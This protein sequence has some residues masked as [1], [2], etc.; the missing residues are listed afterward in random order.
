MSNVR[1]HKQTMSAQIDHIV[2]VAPSL[3]AGSQFVVQSLGVAPGPGRKHPHMGSHNLLLSLG[4]SVY[5]EVAAA[6]PEAA[7]IS[8]RRWFGLDDVTHTS[9]SRLAAWVASTNQI[10]SAASPEYGHAETMRREGRAWQMT[11]TLDGSP[12]LSGAAPVLIQRSGS[13]H[14]AAALA[15]SGLRL[16][17]F[18]IETPDAER[19]RAFLARIDL[20][21]VEVCVVHGAV[22]K[23]IAEIETPLG[24]RTLGD[25]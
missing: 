9:P 15:E 13:A 11:V 10:L 18:R 25:A 20:A 5:L 23:L 7:P 8:R 2:I 4:P 24:L 17:R 22:C 21:Q 12:P 16:R 1:H 3:A 14:P 6:D 19:L